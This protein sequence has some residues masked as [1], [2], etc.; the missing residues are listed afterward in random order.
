M[1]VCLPVILVKRV[2]DRA[3]VVFLKVLVVLLGELL[4]S[5]PFGLVGVGVLQQLVL[6]IWTHSEIVEPLEWGKLTLKSKSY[7][8]SL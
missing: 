3:N 6:D 1:R 2:L 7:L 4:A 5:K 8:P